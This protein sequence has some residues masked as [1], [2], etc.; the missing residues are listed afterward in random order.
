MKEQLVPFTVR[1]TK[2]SQLVSQRLN[3]QLDS[4]PS[5]E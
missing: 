2:L 1:T 3:R 5:D 4:E